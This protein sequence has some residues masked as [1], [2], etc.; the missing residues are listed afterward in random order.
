[1]PNNGSNKNR[2]LHSVKVSTSN[3]FPAPKKGDNAAN[4]RKRISAWLKKREGYKPHFHYGSLKTKD[5]Q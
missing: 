5:T 2:N 1:M 4:E 3:K